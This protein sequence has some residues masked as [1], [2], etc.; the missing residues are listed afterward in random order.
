[1]SAQCSRRSNG[2]ACRPT[3]ASAFV[4]KTVSHRWDVSSTPAR[5]GSTARTASAL[6]MHNAPRVSPARDSR[7]AREAR[8]CALASLRGYVRK[9]KAVSPSPVGRK[10]PVSQG[11][12]VGRAGVDDR[13]NSTSPRVVRRASSVATPFQALPAF[14]RARD[15]HV[16]LARAVSVTSAREPRHAWWSM[17]RTAST[18]LAR[19][20]ASAWP[21][22]VPTRRGR[23]GWSA[24]LNAA[25]ASPLVPRGSCVRGA[26]AGK[27]AL[28]T[29]PRPASLASDA[30]AASRNSRGC[31]SPICSPL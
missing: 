31:A 2:C 29:G 20:R 7:H 19:K 17:V 10:T 25:R 9:G 24:T 15:G 5:G 23:S 8:W 13:A 12:C 6:R 16:Q 4:K 11:C 3:V 22:S 30:C 14:R 1:M 21:S 26:S 27:R 28:P 18:R